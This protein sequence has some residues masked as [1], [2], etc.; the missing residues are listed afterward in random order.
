MKRL[1]NHDDAGCF[2]VLARAA[3]LAVVLL[4]GCTW[5]KF[6]DP[7][8]N[9]GH[10]VEFGTNR[11]LVRAGE[12]SSGR[13]S[14]NPLAGILGG[15][16]TVVQVLD[17]AGNHVATTTADRMRDVQ[18][19]PFDP[20]NPAVRIGGATGLEIWGTQDQTSLARDIANG[21]TN[22]VLI[23]WMGKVWKGLIDETGLTIRALN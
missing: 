4:G 9:P 10:W 5:A 12:Q 19:I 22:I 16:R 14:L 11:N 13:A 21:V 17:Q 23:K 3:L 8:G 1:W 18:V 7:N 2:A 15:G 20:G 6:H